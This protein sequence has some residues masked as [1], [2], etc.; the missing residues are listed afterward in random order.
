MIKSIKIKRIKE[1]MKS[2]SYHLKGKKINLSFSDPDK[3]EKDFNVYRNEKK[4]H[5]Y[6]L[7][8][9]KWRRRLRLT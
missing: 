1:A 2:F 5:V 6:E 7:E 9:K 8:D 3:F 4:L